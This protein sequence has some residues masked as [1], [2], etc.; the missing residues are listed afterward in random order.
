MSE[1]MK[2]LQMIE[3]GEISLEE[4]IQMINNLSDSSYDENEITKNSALDILGK[5]ENGAISADEAVAILSKSK[6]DHQDPDAEAESNQSNEYYSSDFE[7]MPAT[8][9]N[10]PEDELNRWKRWWTYPLYVGLGIVILSTFWL[11]S[12][13][14]N[15]GFGFWFFCSWVPL[16]IGLLII[17]LSWQ[18]RGGPWIHVRVKGETERVAVSI[19]APLGLTSWAL[20]TFGHY[21]PQLEKTS[22][23][24]IIVAL[25]STSKN[26]APLYVQVDEGEN[27]EK[28][29]VFIG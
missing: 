17:S 1:K 4:G 29:E 10:I 23:D 14:Q 3:N 22:V 16:S 19:P 24:E 15:N 13:Y 27:G 5:I 18:S 9:P 8:P 7:E 11:N 20:R 6:L 12:A 2:I 25:E 26:N 21:I 28:V